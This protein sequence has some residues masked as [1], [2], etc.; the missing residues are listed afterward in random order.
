MYITTL[1]KKR[2]YEFER[3]QRR[4]YSREGLEGEKGMRE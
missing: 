4:V 3:E 1:K 2:D